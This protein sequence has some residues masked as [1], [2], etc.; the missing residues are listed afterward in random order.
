VIE[1]PSSARLDP[2]PHPSWPNRRR[3]D[4]SVKKT[5]PAPFTGVLAM[6]DDQL[7]AFISDN[8][9]TFPALTAESEPPPETRLEALNEAI[10]S[11]AI[12]TVIEAIE[13]GALRRQKPGRKPNE[14]HNDKYLTLMQECAAV[15][16]GNM[17]RARKRFLKEAQIRFSVSRGTAENA[18]YRLRRDAAK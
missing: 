15:S 6:S 13:S 17:E 12:E 2:P 16:R 9:I 14:E 10:E 3:V 11:G 5:D 7:S 18:W 1:V 8:K 4:A